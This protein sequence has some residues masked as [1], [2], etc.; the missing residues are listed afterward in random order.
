M[1]VDSAGGVTVSLFKKFTATPAADSLK[2]VA[3]VAGVKD[4][5][6]SPA[7][8]DQ[9]R[10]LMNEIAGRDPGGG[11]WDW[12][13][14]NRP[15]LWRSHVKALHDDDITAARL[16]FNEMLTAWEHRYD[17]TQTDLLAA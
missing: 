12:M 5:L 7:T 6:F 14:S 11:C 4:S 16:S 10:Q 1:A 15:D 8:P 2:S 9:A 3:T 13:K 17:M